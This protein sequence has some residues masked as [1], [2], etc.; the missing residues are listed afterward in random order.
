M[1]KANSWLIFVTLLA[2][3]S[4]CSGKPDNA[5]LL[6]PSPG[7]PRNSE[8]DF[9]QLSDGKTLFV[10]THFTEGMDDYAGAFLAGRYSSDG[11][12][13]WTDKDQMILKN[14][15]MMNIMSVSL[16]RLNKETIAL[17]YLVKNNETDCR[18][19]ARYSIDE[20]Q[21]WSDPVSIMNDTICYAVVNNDRVVLLSG[22]RIIVPAAIH[23]SP[24]QNRFDNHGDVVCY[25]S[26]NT[27]KSW[28]RSRSAL[29]NKS[30]ILQ[31]PGIVEL[32]DDR[33]MMYCRTNAGFQYIS[34]SGDLG[35]TW[36]EMEPSNISSFMSPAA[37][38]R[39]P[40]TGDLLLVWNYRE[41]N[42]TE[43]TTKRSPLCTAVSM[44]EG[45]T[46]ILRKILESEPDHWYCYP[47]VEF[48][49][50]QILLGYCAGSRET[51]NGLQSLKISR[52]PVQWIYE[53]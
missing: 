21:S 48:L 18:P 38:E 24:A 36:T 50:D 2:G 19:F 33:L 15:G 34:Y 27:G 20:S 53:E 10:Y 51:G 25:F 1:Y 31:E 4:A 45:K 8:G 44:D 14:E 7:N 43:I 52:L 29:K 42:D 9:I 6:D 49:E 26:D 37:I 35:D 40:S 39:I 28:S 41:E 46:W 17:F 16:L 11:G 5:L 22:G 23:N 32:G 47:A 13:T 30:V 12:K 3:F